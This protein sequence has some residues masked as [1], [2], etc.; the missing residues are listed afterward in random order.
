MHGFINIRNILLSQV[1]CVRQVVETQ[2]VI[3][4][5]PV[6]RIRPE[7]LYLQVDLDIYYR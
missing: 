7:N 4:N 1:Y 6:L 2:T 3:S 5:N